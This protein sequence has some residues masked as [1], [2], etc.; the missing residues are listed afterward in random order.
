MPRPSR[1]AVQRWMR[2]N[3]RRRS[4]IDGLP[5][6]SRNEEYLFFQSLLGIWPP[7]GADCEPRAKLIERMT[8][9]M[10]K[11]GHEAKQRTSWIN[12]N[13]PYDRAVRDFVATVLAERPTI[14]S[15]PIFSV[16]R[17]ASRN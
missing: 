5:A 15:S 16:T 4:E 10:E 7:H 17:H 14:A 11:A 13:E 6:P 1:T 8:A 2:L 9:Y 3:R 12:P